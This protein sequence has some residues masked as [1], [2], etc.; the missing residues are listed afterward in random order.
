M[1][2]QEFEGQAEAYLNGRL[3][4][5]AATVRLTIKTNDNPVRTSIRGFAGFSRGSED[6]EGSIE[7]PPPRDGFV[8]D[9][10]EAMLRR[11][12]V[13]LAYIDAGKRRQAEGRITQYEM[14]KQVDQTGSVTLSFMGRPVGVGL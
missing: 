13:R 7:M 3:L 12:T 4:T 10:H 14:S 2:M 6:V 11:Q 5:E 1:A 8:V 9:W